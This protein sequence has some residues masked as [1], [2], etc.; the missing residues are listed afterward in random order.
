MLESKDD[1]NL[2]NFLMPKLPNVPKFTKRCH[3]LKMQNDQFLALANKT[4]FEHYLCISTSGY[5]GTKIFPVMF[6]LLEEISLIEDIQTEVPIDKILEWATNEKYYMNLLN[7]EMDYEDE[8]MIEEMKRKRYYIDDLLGNIIAYWSP[9]DVN[10]DFYK[11][12]LLELGPFFDMIFDVIEDEKEQHFSDNF[13]NR[14]ELL[15]ASFRTRY[16]LEDSVEHYTT[17]FLFILLLTAMLKDRR[18]VIDQILNYET[19]ETV[20]LKF[21]SNMRSNESSQYVAQKLLEHGHEIG[22]K[23]IPSSWISQKMFKD[24]L[25]SRIRYENEDLTE[26]DCSFLLHGHTKKYQIESAED[27]DN[28]IVFW[29]DTNSLDFIMQSESLKE[30]LTHPVVS[31][32]IELKTLKYRNLFLWNFWAFVGIFVIPFGALILLPSDYTSIV[33]YICC[34]S[35]AYLVTR[36]VFQLLF[37]VASKQYFR[38]KSNWLEIALI[39]VSMLNLVCNPCHV[40]GF[41]MLPVLEVTLIFLITIILLTMLPLQT[42]S[43]HMKMLGR[44]LR[45]FFKFLAIFALILIAFSV[46][47]GVIFSIKSDVKPQPI[48]FTCKYSNSSESYFNETV[49]DISSNTSGISSTISSP[50]TNDFNNTAEKPDNTEFTENFTSIQTAILKV[51]LMMNGEYTVEPWKLDGWFQLLICFSFVFSTFI[52][53]NLIQGLTFDDVQKLRERARYLMIKQKA[54]KFIETSQKCFEVYRGFE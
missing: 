14:L 13:L 54:R 31:T 40:F 51:I 27:V 4:L 2:L 32:Y 17:S 41:K 21:P 1:L 39:N 47:F 50:T 29:E 19:F 48:A 45:S 18:K 38:K 35:I 6:S 46:S 34:V 8:E 37:V 26:L 53:V 10:Y 12:K 44:V 5:L 23:E 16:V 9:K 33:K 7:L 11:E 36:E 20:K 42:M 25:D 28:K 3:F 52:L 22:K 24:F 15:E 30:S 43:L 49:N